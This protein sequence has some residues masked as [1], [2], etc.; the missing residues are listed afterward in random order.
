MKPSL[1]LLEDDSLIIDSICEH[2]GRK[3]TITVASTL[4][5]AYA[6]LEET[7]FTILLADRVLPDGD[8]IEIIEYC[9]DISPNTKIISCSQLSSVDERLHGLSSGADD[10]LP[11]PFS[12]TELSIKVQNFA[13]FSRNIADDSLSAGK[14]SLNLSNGELRYANTLLGSLRKKEAEIFSVLLKTANQTISKKYLISEAWLM[15]ESVP[16]FTTLD[17]YIRRIRMVLKQHAQYL[18]TVRGFGYSFKPN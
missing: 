6:A 2:L 14:F 16:T 1:L 12:L 9:R 11:K 15:D 8:G 10:Y 4:D 18:E 17:V 7:S 13:T 5:L 3:F